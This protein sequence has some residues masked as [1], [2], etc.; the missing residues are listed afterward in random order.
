MKK[1][2]S[3]IDLANYDFENCQ[4]GDFLMMMKSY[5]HF[6]S[7][8]P[9]I[10]AKVNIVE[11]HIKCMGSLM[12]LSNSN[13]FEEKR[14]FFSELGR[15]VRSRMVGSDDGSQPSS[16]FDIKGKLIIEL[17]EKGDEYIE[18]FVPDRLGIIK[19]EPDLDDDKFLLDY[20]FLMTIKEENIRPDRFNQ[21]KR[22]TCKA[23]FYQHTA[24]K[25]EYCSTKCSGAKRQATLRKKTSKR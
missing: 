13:D 19:S 8:F 15:H 11:R 4:E 5:S 21:C 22:P 2:E 17:N 20:A 18:Q 12:D 10:T 9:V 3:L 16:I 23:I 6:L 14:N 24:K 1:I 25:K 7:E